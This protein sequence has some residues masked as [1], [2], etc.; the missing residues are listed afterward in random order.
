M[1]MQGSEYGLGSDQDFEYAFGSFKGSE[2]TE[3]LNV[4]S[5]H[6]ILDMSEYTWIISEYVWLCLNMPENA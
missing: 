3:I 6:R 5:L 4:L 2:Y 1:S